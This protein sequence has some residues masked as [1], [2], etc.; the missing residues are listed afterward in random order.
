VLQLVLQA[1]DLL[2][3]Q[4]TRKCADSDQAPELDLQRGRS[5]AQNLGPLVSGILKAFPNDIRR[6][7]RSGSR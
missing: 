7:Y 1:D 2:D 4:H 6:T 5:E 3:K